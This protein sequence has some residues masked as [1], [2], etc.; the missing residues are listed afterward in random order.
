[1]VTRP[2]HARRRRIP[3]ASSAALQP[4]EDRRLMSAVVAT[5]DTAGALV[6]AD[7]AGSTVSGLTPAQVRHAYGFDTLTFNG[8]KTAATGAGETIAVVDAYNDPN[9]AADLAAFDAKFGLATA[10][11]TVV[12]QTGSTTSLPSTD[13]GWGQEISLDV[14]WAHAIAPGAKI[15]L[16]E[17]SSDSTADLLAAVKYAR[18]HAGVDAVSMSWGSSE[19]NGETA[20]DSVFTTPTGHAGVTFVSASGDDGSSGGAEWPSASAYVLSVG[21]TTLTTTGTAGTYSSETGWADGGGGKSVYEGEPSYQSKVQS[22]DVREVPDV[23][24]DADPDTGFAV[25][26]SLTYERESGWLEFG[27]TSAAAP[28]WAAL[29][30]VA[31]QGREAVGEANLDGP[32]NVLPTLYALAANGTSYAADFHDVTSGS[33]GAVSA[34][35]GYDE[36]TGIGT[37]KSTSLIDALVATATGYYVSLTAVPVTSSPTP[38]HGGW[39]GWGGPGGGGPGGGPGRGFVAVADAA[40]TSVKEETATPQAVPLTTP[41]FYQIA[42]SVNAGS[43]AA[44]ATATV[45]DATPVA[46]DLTGDAEV[47]PVGPFADVA[48]PVPSGPALTS[49]PIALAAVSDA[50]AGI[51]LGTAAPAA[52]VLMV[53]TPSPAAQGAVSDRTLGVVGSVL[54]G[55][56]AFAAWASAEFARKPKDETGTPFGSQLIRLIDLA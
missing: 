50:P 15:L 34:G 1:M 21:G 4:L 41:Q 55:G 37:P 43:A 13:A 10:S 39:G 18:G 54:V 20:D 46:A 44:G 7:A 2:T 56:I 22:S 25:Y 3:S 38:T 33:S 14:E 23:S 40:T 11:L 35:T 8:G 51:E 45:A 28:Q 26:D 30:T 5:P 47:V 52:T 27:G 31:D 29:V 17:A 42:L 9:I 49:L 48:E 36:V 19:F 16:V 24:Y 12:G 53:A 32:T 6:S